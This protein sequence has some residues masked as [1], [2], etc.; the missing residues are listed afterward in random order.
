MSDLRGS[1]GR[2]AVAVA[3]YGGRVPRDPVDDAVAEAER[4]QS[5]SDRDLSASV[6][7]FTTTVPLVCRDWGLTVH[8]WLS[9]G[10]GTPPLAVSCADGRSA[11]LKIA[12]PGA[13]D[14]QVRV[15]EAADGHGYARVLRWDTGRG[16]VLLERLGHDLWTESAL[17]A[18]QTRVLVPLLR[19]AWKVPLS[20]GAPFRSKAAGLL[21]IIAGL[22]PR[23]AADHTRAIDLATR[24]ATQLA[25]SERAEVVCHGD[26]H[27]GNVL[28][29]STGWALIDPDGF[30]GER[31]YDLGV[32]M[33]DAC[34]ELAA[35]ELAQPGTALPTLRRECHQLA[36]LAD[37]DPA[38]VWQWAFVERVTTGLYLGWH[39]HTDESA[40]FLD[41]ATLLAGSQDGA[42]KRH[43]RRP[44]DPRIPR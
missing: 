15:L 30:I 43:G 1:A 28:R 3:G 41:S 44:S 11:V 33:R 20:S 31:A 2:R 25:A 17:L 5:I 36:S 18:D 21:D 27:P 38:R 16:A 12:E 39:G 29:R 35:T 22:G 9:G 42:G 26:P 14:T 8:G 24:Y 32:A 40:T 4:R 13:L 34:R 23:Y 19:N 37:I 7:H 10:A 6:E